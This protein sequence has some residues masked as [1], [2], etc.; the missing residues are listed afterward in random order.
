[1]DIFVRQVSSNEA[2][3][4]ETIRARVKGKGEGIA[5]RASL[6]IPVDL[7]MHE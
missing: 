3:D 5:V 7:L 2:R 4:N 1:M 6:S